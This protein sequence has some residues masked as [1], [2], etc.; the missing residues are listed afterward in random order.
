[1]PEKPGRRE[2]DIA[3]FTRDEVARRG[4]QTAWEPAQCPLVT[5]GPVS[6]DDLWGDGGDDILIGDHGYVTQ[7]EGTLRILTTGEVERIETVIGPVDPVGDGP[8]GEA[9]LGKP[10]ALASVGTSAGGRVWLVAEGRRYELE[11]FLGAVRAGMAQPP[12]R[13][14]VCSSQ[15]IKRS[16]S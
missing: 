10:S 3:S 13:W 4:V 15:R 16:A 14:R 11:R 5:T 8:V 12:S 6:R 2:S 1:L 7:A 9:F